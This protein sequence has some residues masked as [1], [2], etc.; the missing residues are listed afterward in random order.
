MSISDLALYEVW[1]LQVD[2][3]KT[4]RW[5]FFLSESVENGDES[6]PRF[7]I[8]RKRLENTKKVKKLL[9]HHY[10]ARLVKG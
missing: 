1:W 3:L 5:F 4:L 6:G 8:V 2:F 10:I 7:K 9:L